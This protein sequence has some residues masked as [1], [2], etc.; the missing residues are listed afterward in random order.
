VI[1]FAQ[2]G[3]RVNKENIALVRTVITELMESGR[4]Q[5]DAIIDV[6]GEYDD[7]PS[8]EGDF[9]DMGGWVTEAS[10]GTAACLAGWLGRDPRVN[11]A[12]LTLE[13]GFEDHLVP[14]YGEHSGMA[15]LTAWLDI[16]PVGTNLIFGA[17]NPNSFSPGLERLERVVQLEEEDAAAL[18]P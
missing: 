4:I 10:C 3:E 9:L 15:A 13:E 11:A 2:K 7:D 6:H 8:L 1:F 5:E 18:R 12:G 16:S 14:C 17:N